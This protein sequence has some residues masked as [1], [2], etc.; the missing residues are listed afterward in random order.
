MPESILFSNDRAYR[1]DEVAEIL[2]VHERTIR[3]LVNEIDEKERLRSYKIKTSI[4]IPGPV[5][6]QYLQDHE[7]KPEWE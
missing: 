6:N 1:I 3:R 2:R 7:V 4:R 5:I